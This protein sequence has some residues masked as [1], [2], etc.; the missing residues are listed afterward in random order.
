MVDK[1]V[2]ALVLTETQLANIHNYMLNVKFL[3][4]IDFEIFGHWST[5]IC[6][7]SFWQ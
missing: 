1:V 7:L 3:M 4:K 5:V 6:N 2:T